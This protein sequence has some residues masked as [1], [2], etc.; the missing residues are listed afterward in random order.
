MAL[1]ECQTC[2]GPNVRALTAGNASRP[3]RYH[4]AIWRRHG[5]QDC[6]RTFFSVQLP[7]D[8]DEIERF[9]ERLREVAEA[10]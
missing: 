5:C 3:K 9:A 8:L 7:A 10:V 6:G 2:G 1:W 4:G